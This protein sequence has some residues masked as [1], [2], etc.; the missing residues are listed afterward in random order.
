MYERDCVCAWKLRR[1][2]G[3][4]LRSQCHVGSCRSRRQRGRSPGISWDVPGLQPVW[5]LPL[6]IDR[7]HFIKLPTTSCQPVRGLDRKVEFRAIKCNLSPENVFSEG[8]WAPAAFNAIPFIHGRFL[9]NRLILGLHS[10]QICSLSWAC[11][12]ISHPIYKPQVEI[13]LGKGR[14][15]RGSACKAGLLGEICSY[16]GSTGQ[17]F[18]AL[19][20][21]GL[22]CHLLVLLSRI[23]SL[24]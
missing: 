14:G 23:T 7:T 19:E 6:L 10:K 24:P 20:T 2:P 17:R 9:Q 5:S 21:P 1:C 12:R 13:S 15:C 16:Q 18:A 11:M 22:R 4:H 8:G 3:C